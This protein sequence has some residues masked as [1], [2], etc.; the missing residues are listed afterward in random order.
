VRMSILALIWNYLKAKKLN[1]V[2]NILLLA[3]GIA[4]ITILILFNNQMQEKMTSN[5][6]GIDLA[7]KSLLKKIDFLY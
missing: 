4:V 1:T 7:G 3:L 6:K 2:L 5:A